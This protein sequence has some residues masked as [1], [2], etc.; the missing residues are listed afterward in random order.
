MGDSSGKQALFPGLIFGEDGEPV[1]V[2]TI[3]G[4]PFYVI[5]NAGF[6]RHVEAETVDLQV[7]EWLR[8]QVLS[9]QDL[10]TEGMMTLL[11][12]D[13]LFTKAMID[14]SIRDLDQQMEALMTQGLPEGAQAWLGM[15]GFR[16]VVDVHG[17]VV[18]IQAA[19]SGEIEDW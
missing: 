15:L 5:L 12:K 8:E 13:D 10:V 14:A 6:R 16:V 4:A 9:N 17:E 2:T 3:G 1:E 11:G 19:A 7:L 18:E